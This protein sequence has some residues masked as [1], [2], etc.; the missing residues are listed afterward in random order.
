MASAVIGALRVNLSIDTAAF[1]DG[2]NTLPATLNKVG[3]RMQSVGAKMSTFVTAPVIAAGTAV[4][5]ALSGMSQEINQISNSARLAG[6][7]FQEFQK[8]AFGAKTV[9][10]ESE[11]LGDIFKDTQDKVGDFLS[12]GGGEMKDFFETIAP[13]VGVTAEAF[14]GLSGPQ[15]LQL[16]YSSLEKAG[17]SQA[18]MTFY[19]EAIADEASGLIPLLR[20]G[21]A[22]FQR[23]GE[24]AEALGGIYSDETAAQAQKFSEAMSS[25]G[26]A[27]RG[28]GVV[29]ANSG[30]IEW[31]T[32]AV[33]K[34]TEFAVYLNQTDP[35]IVKWGAVVAGIAAV[36]GPAVTA[37]GLMVVAVS[38]IS[39]PVIAAVAAGTAL[40]AAAVA[41][42]TNWDQIRAS[43]PIVG[44]IVDTAV[45]V[46]KTSL[47]G[48]VENARLMAT[49]IAQILTG[50]FA[51]AWN[52]ALALLNNFW[53]TFGT[54]A[55]TII[56]G[57]TAKLGE[58][59][60]GVLQLAADIVNAFMNLPAQMIEIGGQIIDGLWQ[61]IK[62]K[63]EQLKAGVTSIGN[64]IVSWF[65]NPLQ[66]HSPSR[67]MHAVGVNVMQGLQN[68][69]DSM[70]A[71][72]QGT[73]AGAAGDVEGAMSGLDQ[74]GQSLS[75]SIGD[76]FAGFIKGGEAAKDAVANLAKQLANF[77]L[78]D[79]LKALSNAFGGGGSSGGGFGSIL[80]SVFRALVPGAY[81]GGSIMPGGGVGGIGGIDNQLVA[82]RK[83]PSEQVDI[84]DPKRSKRGGGSAIFRQ[85][86]II[87]Q[88]DA[89]EKTVA[90]IDARLKENNQRLAY[91]QSNS[92]R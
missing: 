15:A 77:A 86:D 27:L 28:L 55:D 31:V 7:G 40:A 72:V 90:L 17:V 74:M 87:I 80:G 48:L 33:Q 9:G 43:F 34:I 84:Y 1:R 2:L 76:L 59:G 69:M 85:G 42:Y 26:A 8:L 45:A 81:K 35:Q 6:A 63:A 12:S 5:A 32:A 39:G 36:V 65:K 68:G 49:G 56:P 57:F 44:Q 53:Q 25:L 60:R 22:E 18:E 67:V 64:G 66:I 92:W 14:R 4:T 19:M 23:Y 47:M 73:A 88:G 3:K 50:D 41:I 78:N 30:L 46:M 89:S 10:I 16:Y 58:M 71:G 13:K 61:G 82:F 21:G 20:N 70:R 51:G 79:G 24:K 37:L 38:A 54:I 75:S 11:K 91:S 29:I 62:A 83:K 52:S